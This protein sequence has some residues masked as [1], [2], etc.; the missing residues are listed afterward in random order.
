MTP[1]EYDAWRDRMPREYAADH[2]RAGNWSAD[3]SLR[4]AEADIDALLPDGLST[5]RM[6]LLTG[7]NEGGE[8]IGSV[9]VCLDHPRGAVDC[10]WV[11][12]IRVD[13]EHRGQGYGRLLLDATESAVRSRGLNAIMLNVF[14]H[15]RPALA[16]YESAGYATASRH[17]RKPLT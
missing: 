13:E 8:Q 14:G 5:N 3:D 9:W 2:V 17:M 16:L 11:Y 4:R 10:A 1:S 6:L 12:D 15:N 7:V